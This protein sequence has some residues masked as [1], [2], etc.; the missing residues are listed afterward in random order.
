MATARSG[1]NAQVSRHTKG[2]LAPAAGADSALRSQGKFRPRGDLVVLV[3][4]P[5]AMQLYI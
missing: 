3:W 2:G 4:Q 5:Q 1:A